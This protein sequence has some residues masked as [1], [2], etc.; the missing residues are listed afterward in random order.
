M[1]KLRK[2]MQ[3]NHKEHFIR[4][5][6]RQPNHYKCQWCNSHVQG[7]G[8]QLVQT[9]LGFGLRG[10]SGPF[11][12]LLTALDQQATHVH[13]VTKVETKEDKTNRHVH[14]K[15]LFVLHLLKFL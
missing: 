8:A 1:G 12:M 2:N 14:F 5:L 15:S 9:E 10:G 6:L 4:Q 3:D 13:L 11:H 7:A